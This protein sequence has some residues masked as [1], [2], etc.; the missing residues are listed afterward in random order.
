MN[1]VFFKNFTLILLT[2]FLVSFCVVQKSPVTGS[3]RAYAYS[4]EQEKEI[5]KKVDQQIQQQYGI[6]EGDV[7]EYVKDVAHKVLA[8]SHMRREDTPKK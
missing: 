5:G 7:V 3:K 2:A 6:Y 1:T 4:W 8:V